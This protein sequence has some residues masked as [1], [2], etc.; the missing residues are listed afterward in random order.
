MQCILE[1]GG[2]VERCRDL[3]FGQGR[4]SDQAPR[5]GERGGLE[6]VGRRSGVQADGK[7]VLEPLF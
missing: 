3:G 7:T 6:E 1:E 5:R 2:R 4:V